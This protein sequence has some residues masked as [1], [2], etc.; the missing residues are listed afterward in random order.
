MSHSLGQKGSYK[1][2][3]QALQSSKRTKDLKGLRLP[4]KEGSQRPVC[5]RDSKRCT[6]AL[7]MQS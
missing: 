3:V 7:H 2:T 5:M 6:A 1:Q 4:E